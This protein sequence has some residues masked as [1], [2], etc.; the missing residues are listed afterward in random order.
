MKKNPCQIDE[1]LVQIDGEI[2]AP[3]SKDTYP[4][5]IGLNRKNYDLHGYMTTVQLYT[6]YITLNMVAFV[7]WSPAMMQIDWRVFP[8]PIS[9]H[10]VKISK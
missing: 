8:S 1:P 5:K 7:K 3:L 6:G 4:S 2:E 9:I 10:R